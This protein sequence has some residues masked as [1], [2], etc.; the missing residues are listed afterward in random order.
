MLRRQIIWNF[1]I[2]QGRLQA[3]KGQ[4]SK[5]AKLFEQGAAVTPTADAFY[6]LG[7]AQFQLKKYREALESTER[8]IAMAGN[9][10]ARQIR[11]GAL[12]E[13]VGRHIDAVR[14]YST[15]LQADPGNVGLSKRLT[16]AE[17]N[18]K[19]TT[20][21][22]VAAPK[23]LSAI[24]S[25][26]EELDGT[27]KTLLATGEPWK[28][29][30]FLTKAMGDDPKNAI[31]PYHCGLTELQL[32]REKLAVK[33]F[34]QAAHLDPDDHSILFHQA[35][36]MLR[37][38]QPEAIE[39]TVTKGLALKGAAVDKDVE[40][41]AFF[42]SK[43]LWGPAAKLYEHRLK[44]KP[45][46]SDLNYRLGV[47]HER[48]QNWSS[49]A[50]FHYRALI[51]EPESAARHFRYATA[52]ER[53][54]RFTEAAEAYAVAVRLTKGPQT[55]WLYRQASALNAAGD[56]AGAIA[57]FIRLYPEDEALLWIEPGSSSEE[58]DISAYESELLAKNLQHALTTHDPK[59]LYER[60]SAFLRQKQFD[61]AA[62]ALQAAVRQQSIHKPR[63]YFRLALAQLAAGY[64]AE[65]IESFR[66][67]QK[68]RGPV[69]IGSHSY[70]KKEWQEKA[71][72]YVE[73]SQS[74]ALEENT[75]LFES[76]QGNRVDCNPAAIYRELRSDHRYSHMRF[77]WIIGAKT[78]IPDD[79]TNDPR[80][81][82]VRHGSDLYRR[83]LATA[84][85]LVSNVTFLHYFV[86]REGQRY[87]NTWHGTPLKA[88]GKDI[89][90]GFMQHGNVARNFIQATHILAPN[91]HTHESLIRGHDVEGLFTGKV[92]RLGTPR[93]D[94]MMSISPARRSELFNRL[95]LA[96]DGR[97][98]IFYA[99][100]WRGSR[101]SKHFDR[102]K[103]ISDL[104][105]LSKRN[106]HV[107]FRAHRLTEALLKGVDLDVTLVPADIDSY[108]VLGITDVLITDYSSIFF[109][110]LPARRPI[111][112]YAYD[113]DEY[114]SERGLYFEL[115]KMPGEIARTIVELG[116][117]LDRA[118]DSGIQNTEQYDRA[119]EEFAP[120]EQGNAAQRAVAFLMEDDVEFVVDL[121][122]TNRELILFRHNFA[123]GA[124]TEAVLDFVSKLDPS[125]FR[126]IVQFDRTAIQHSPA[127]RAN[128]DRLPGHVQ[129]LVRSGEF[130]ASVE[131]RWVINTFNKAHSWAN[132]E[133]EGI[134]RRAFERE[135]R[136]TI[137]T[138]KFDEVFQIAS[139]DLVGRAMLAS[140]R[141][142]A[143]NR[144]L[145]LDR[146]LE[147]VRRG[148]DAVDVTEALPVAGWYDNLITD[149]T[150]HATSQHL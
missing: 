98:V 119:V 23:K 2:Q 136:R 123:P 95:G 12:Y 11:L 34:S 55:D 100:T 13:R 114:L 6:Y 129:R 26:I 69:S 39:A 38:D 115:S 20:Q 5:A 82:L 141:D 137:G 112:F 52:L 130:L 122:Q 36:A 30:A 134:F 90:G 72:Q 76:Y 25:A 35:L 104:S 110:F 47:A 128:V 1:Y 44:M 99:P 60:G 42:Q 67:T 43:G 65:A 148:T 73:Y 29:L 54:C 97:Q 53:L 58:Y 19:D 138:A 85:Y 27:T 46:H 94:R 118:A 132:A 61:I 105:T 91:N 31:W 78:M 14:V 135:F 93:I 16:R 51:F 144:V 28:R 102:D 37:C 63:W 150:E 57:A 32:G 120:R 140:S 111:V 80:V 125:R 10:P 66:D 126:V 79:V 103:L 139:D 108:D 7:N 109:D 146:T 56:T 4:W 49:A 48:L 75:V 117:C 127:R 113:L 22:A 41:G 86:R 50:T 15:A 84:K 121:P 131:E 21:I 33:Y 8:S 124:T 133:Q 71:M 96:D 62:T 147:D 149:M 101:D 24:E 116:E 40:P 87:L 68:F 64:T 70:F 18:A 92:A 142:N 59:H 88:L 106:A 107:V 143:R 45:S 81:S 17:K 83:S 9:D 74:L 145:F 89:T 77:V 3:R